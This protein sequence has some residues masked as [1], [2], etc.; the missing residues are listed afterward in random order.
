MDGTG[1][2]RE[3]GNRDTTGCEQSKAQHD[4]RPLIAAVPADRSE[5]LL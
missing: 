2:E 4:K 5:S 3:C 1:S